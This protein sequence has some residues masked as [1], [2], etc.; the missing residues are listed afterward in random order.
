MDARHPLRIAYERERWLRPDW[1][2][3]YPPGFQWP[4]EREAERKRA[5]LEAREA[6]EAAWIEVENARADALAHLRWM[7]KDLKVELM[8][9]RLRHKYSPDQPRVPA[10]NRDGGQWTSGGAG[11]NDPRVISDTT[12]DPVRPGAQ[13]AQGDRLQGYPI[14]LRDEDARGGHTIEAHVNRGREALIAQ[15]LEAFDRDPHA[16]NARSGSFSSLDAA[17]KLVNSTLAQN[18]ATVTQVAN[19]LQDR[20]VVFASFD[21]VT[22]IEAVIP[23]RRSQPYFQE[24]Y[25]VGVV[26]F[27]DRF[28][29]RGFTVLTAFPTNH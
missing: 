6:E 2:R 27:H 1:R 12:P 3:W 24:T 8:L 16:E 9:R 18:Q 10:G 22:G 15:A 29:P 7:L 23:N 26:I 28:S 13:Y 20:V 17:T 4:E 5:E 19:G 14:D 25:D 11:R 21:S